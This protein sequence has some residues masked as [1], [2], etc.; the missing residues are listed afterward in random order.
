MQTTRQLAVCKI[1]DE[2]MDEHP[3]YHEEITGEEAEKRLQRCTNH[4]YLTRHSIKNQHYILSVCK[5]NP[6]GFV[7]KHFPIIFNI[8]GCHKK[9]RIGQK[10]RVF[11]NLKEMLEFYE[12]NR[13]D[14]ALNKIG[15]CVTENDYVNKIREDNAPV[16]AQAQNLYQAQNLSQAENQAEAQPRTQSIVSNSTTPQRQKKCIIL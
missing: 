12:N 3:S 1:D 10:G 15:Q 8:E 6:A 14:P 16:G 2:I 4:G 9:Y 13:I 7:F 11:N 5:E